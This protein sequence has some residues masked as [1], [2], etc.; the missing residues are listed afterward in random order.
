MVIVPIGYAAQELFDVSRGSRRRR[1]SDYRWAAVH[2]NQAE[3]LISLAIGEYV[4]LVAAVRPQRLIFNRRIRMP[5]QKSKAHRVGE[6]ASLRV[7]RR[8]KL[9]KPFLKSRS[10][11]DENWQKNMGRR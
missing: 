9:P 4:P 3:T 10:L 2:V 1:R 8:R 5:T 6:W 11:Y 7:I